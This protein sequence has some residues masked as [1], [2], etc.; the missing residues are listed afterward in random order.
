MEYYENHSFTYSC[1]IAVVVGVLVSQISQKYAKLHQ[2]MIL[3][4]G[5]LSAEKTADKAAAVRV[6]EIFGLDL[7]I[8]L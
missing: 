5:C 2:R 6:C 7:V 3:I 8:L 1:S 4:T